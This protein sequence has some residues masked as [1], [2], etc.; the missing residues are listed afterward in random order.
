MKA[1]APVLVALATIIVVPAVRAGHPGFPVHGDANCNSAVNSI[2]AVLIL[3]EDAGLIASDCAENADTN[4]DTT[5]NS[6][7]AALVLQFE[8]A[9]LKHLGPM[10]IEIGNDIAAPGATASV[11]LH[12]VVQ[13]PGLTGWEIDVGYNASVLTL[14]ACTAGATSACD[15]SHGA[16]IV[17]VTG[18]SAEPIIGELMMAEL[19][20][21]CGEGLSILTLDV[22]GLEQDTGH[23]GSASSGDPVFAVHNNNI[24][25]A[26]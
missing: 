21:T 6:L 4:E 10:H 22:V 14:A 12:A 13:P 9:L 7:D 25:C 19:E 2:D 15:T 5:I 8:A 1:L 17:T 18:A 24:I 23:H 3:R 26:G 16:G 11:M 20:F